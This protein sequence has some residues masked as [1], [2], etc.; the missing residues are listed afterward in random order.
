[1][2]I[3]IKSIILILSLGYKGEI[4]NKDR[5]FVK[6]NWRYTTTIISDIKLINRIGTD[7]FYRFHSA[8]ISSSVANHNLRDISRNIGANTVLG[9]DFPSRP[10]SVFVVQITRI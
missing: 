3:I 6:K 9:I 7:V 8:Y 1:M 4:S 10:V 2:Q 5:R